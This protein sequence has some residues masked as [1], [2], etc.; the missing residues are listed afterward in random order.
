MQADV[1]QD[2]EVRRL[3]DQAVA[4]FGRLDANAPDHLPDGRRENRHIGQF[5]SLHCLV[6]QG[7]RFSYFSY[8][9]AHGCDRGKA[10]DVHPINAETGLELSGPDDLG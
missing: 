10:K 2:A 6:T 1:P 8:P 5:S 9:V 4:R 3:V 7:V